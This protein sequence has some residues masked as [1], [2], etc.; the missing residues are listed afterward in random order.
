MLRVPSLAFLACL[1]AS[2]LASGLALGCASETAEQRSGR[3]PSRPIRISSRESVQLDFEFDGELVTDFSWND[4][5]TIQ[6]Q[7]LYT[8]GQ[9]N[10]DQQRRPPRQPRAHEHPKT[11]RADG[12]VRSITYHAKLPVA[13]GSKTN[14]PT[15]LRVQAAAGHR[16]TRATRRSPTKYK[17]RLRRLRRARRRRRLDVVLL[18]ARSVSGCKH[19]RG[20]RRDSHR[21]ASRARPR[22][23]PASTPSTTRSG[24]TTRSRSS[25]SSASTRTARRPR[26]RRH[27]RVQRRSSRRCKRELGALRD[28]TT[29]AGERRRRARASRRRD[30]AFNA[31]LA[32]GKKV[33]VIAL[34]VDNV[35]TAPAAFDARY[36]ALSPRA[37][38]IAYNGHAGLGR[39]S[40]RSR[41]RASW[42]AGKYLMRLHERLRHVRVRRRLAR[43]DARAAQPRRP[44][45]HEVHGLRHQR[46]CRRSSARCPTRRSRCS[47]ACSSST[48]PK[49]LRADLRD[50]RHARRS[51]S[52]PAKRTTSS[53]PAC[54]SAP[55]AAAVAALGVVRRAERHG[56]KAQEKR[57][58]TPELP[59]G[60][61]T[62]VASPARRR[63]RPLR[64]ASA[65]RR[66]PRRYDCRP[67]KTGS[68]RPARSR[69]RSRRGQR[70]GP[71]LRGASTF[72][73]TSHP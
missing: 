26:R 8:I 33:K 17:A 46:A 31:T 27:R 70:D 57:Y 61:Y 59:A 12:K 24:K 6:D 49:T 71:R 44:D 65:P 51:C 14:L 28:L 2:I 42:V 16:A 30:V 52:S 60:T 34:L 39:T 35:S 10:G 3:T 1:S 37:D 64:A 56:R 15:T 47:T 58:A 50:D 66:R 11:H 38:F 5:Q 7:L 20:R 25:R 19:R 72:T 18:P 45:G 73:L 54:R 53:R 48:T 23:R 4:K 40:A 43:P 67:Y 22:T 21:D 62:F 13:W 63:R 36:E 55:A 9:L 32:D 29:D 41:A 68:P 69:S